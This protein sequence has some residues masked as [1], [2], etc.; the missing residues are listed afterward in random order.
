MIQKKLL[1]AVTAV[2]LMWASEAQATA[3]LTIGNTPQQ[4]DEN[5]LLNTGETGNPIFGETNQTHLAVRFTGTEDLTAP[6]QGQARIEAAD[7]FFDFLKIDVPAGSFSSLILNL[8]V[9]IAVGPQ[10]M[11]P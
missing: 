4:G 8:D 5:I 6:A 11:D 7:G 10:E 9:T 1:V 2:V 3:I